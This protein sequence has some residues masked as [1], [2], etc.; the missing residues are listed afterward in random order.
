M[1]GVPQLCGNKD[2][3]SRNPPSGKSCLQGLTHLTLVAVSFRTIE[4]PKS[5]FQRASGSTYRLGCIGNQGAKPEYGHMAASVVERHARIPKSR[6]FDHDDTLAVARVQHH[7][8][9]TRRS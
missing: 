2:V 8:P 1:I 5:S 7:L 9:D 6:R 3:F 4:V